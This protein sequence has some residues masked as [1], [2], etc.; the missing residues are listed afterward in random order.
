LVDART[1]VCSAVGEPA[2]PAAE[3]NEALCL[4]VCAQVHVAA[5]Y[6]VRE[7]EAPGEML[8]PLVSAMTALPE[9]VCHAVQPPQDCSTFRRHPDECIYVSTDPCHLGIDA[10][11]SDAFL[12]LSGYTNQYRLNVPS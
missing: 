7:S 3:N 5:K 4:S 1:V 10:T 9:V 12:T 11:S 6:Q 8:L 2:K